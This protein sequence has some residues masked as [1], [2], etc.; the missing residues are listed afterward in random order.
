MKT[1]KLKLTVL[2]DRNPV[3]VDDENNVVVGATHMAWLVVGKEKQL[4][5]ASPS[6]VAEFNNTTVSV[7]ADNYG[8][9]L[10]FNGKIII[11]P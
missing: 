2:D 3:L 5:P 1:I 4:I 8:K 10:M 11:I 6:Y 7:Q 9:P